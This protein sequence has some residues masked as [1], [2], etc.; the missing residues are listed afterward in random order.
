MQIAQPPGQRAWEIFP[1]AATDGAA[2][3]QPQRLNSH[4]AACDPAAGRDLASE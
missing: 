1:L 2:Q 3:A 4:A